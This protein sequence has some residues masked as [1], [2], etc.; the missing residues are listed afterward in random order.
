MVSSGPA[1]AHGNPGSY[2]TA[3][4]SVRPAVPGLVVA[5]ESDGSYLTI[6]NRTGRSLIVAGYEQ[7]AYLRITAQGTWENT[8]SPTAWINAGGTERDQPSSVSAQAMPEWRQV[9]DSFTYRYHDHRIGWTG[10]GLPTV[11][12]GDVNRPHL[13][14]R[15]S[16][17]LTMDDTQITVSGSLTWSPTGF[18]LAQ[19]LFVLACLALIVGIVAVIVVEGRRPV[20]AT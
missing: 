3:I 13:I 20:A 16:V 12:A 8:R 11:V 19:V 6:T 2:V 10:E 14:E 7:E 4:T 9:S 18:G 1:A 5:A 15:W 17:D